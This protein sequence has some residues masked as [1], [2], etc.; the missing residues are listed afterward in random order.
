MRTAGRARV[1]EQSDADDRTRQINESPPASTRSTTPAAR[2]A[3]KVTHR[4]R[5]G[6]GVPARRHR[7][8]GRGRRVVASA[9]TDAARDGRRQRPGA[10]RRR[11]PGVHDRLLEHYARRRHHHR[12]GHDLGRRRRHARARRHASPAADLHGATHIARLA[13]I[14]PDCTLTDTVV[15]A[16][17]PVSSRRDQGRDRRGRHR[18]PVRLPAPRHGARRR[19]ARRHLCRGEGQRVGDGQQGP[20][21]VLR[22]RRRRSASSTNIGAATVFVNYDGVAKHRTV[23]GDH[24]RTGADTMF[25]APVEIGDGAYTAAGSVITEDVPP[26]ALAVAARASS[27]TWQAGCER[28]RRRNGLRRA[29]PSGPR[30]RPRGRH[31]PVRGRHRPGRNCSEHASR[32]PAARA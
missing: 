10:A 23:V 5:A 11:A 29:P 31:S 26:G 2:G 27:A 21:P 18:R 8:A 25:V 14:G 1:V 17:A 4:Q 22:R 16:G 19:R 32:S 12:P 9:A 15:G 7:S 13:A 30:R 24:V 3:G 20:A 28:R 6:R